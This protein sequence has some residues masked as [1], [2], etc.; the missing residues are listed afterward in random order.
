MY[1]SDFICTY[2]Q[3]DIEEEQ[4]ILYKIQ[5]LQA[6]DLNE[7]NDN[8]INEILMRLFKSMN[9]N[10]HMHR[11]L[12]K[13]SHAEDIQPLLSKIKNDNSN[14]DLEHEF[15]LFN[16]LFQYKYFDLFHKCVTEFE[17]KGGMN[18]KTVN[19]LLNEM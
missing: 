17:H 4:E 7:F 5:L 19:A 10:V 11:I 6:F 1:K 14:Y 9:V 18:D 15:I 12:E 3:M 2:K 8:L 13:L 16:L